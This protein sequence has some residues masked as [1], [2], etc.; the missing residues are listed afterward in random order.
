MRYI[1]TKLAK[2]KDK[3]RLWAQSDFAQSDF[4]PNHDNK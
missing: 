1:T 2:G 4:T 3:L